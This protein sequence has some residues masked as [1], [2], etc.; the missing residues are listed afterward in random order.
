MFT[1][2]PWLV[3]IAVAIP[4]AVS[5]CSSS[6]T[7]GNADSGATSDANASAAASASS[8]ASS[9]TDTNASFG[10]TITYDDGLAV[11]VTDKGTFKPSEYAAKEK[12]K[13]Y[14]KYQVTLKNGTDKSIDP[15]LIYPTLQDGEAEASSVTDVEKKIGVPPTTKL[16]PGRTVKWNVAYGVDT[17]D[18]VMEVAIN[19][20]THDSAI[21][22]SK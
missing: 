5:G 16:L 7:A 22:T 10:Q 18:L 3:A 19:D 6:G 21:Y 8:S 12:A 11:T 15:V 9:K 2:A 4:L 14:I 1:R 20:F 13:R 17:D